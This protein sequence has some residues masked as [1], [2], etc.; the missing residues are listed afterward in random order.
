MKNLLG[1]AI[2]CGV[3]M[4]APVVSTAGS[5]EAEDAVSDSERS[6][7]GMVLLH[8]LSGVERFRCDLSPLPASMAA[9]DVWRMVPDGLRASLRERVEL[10]REKLQ[11]P[12]VMPLPGDFNLTV[13]F[14][15]SVT[16][17]GVLLMV[18]PFLPVTPLLFSTFT[19]LYTNGTLGEWLRFS[20]FSFLSPF[21]GISLYVPNGAFV[22][23][24]YAGLV[25]ATTD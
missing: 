13:N 4:L 17:I 5:V 14:L 20:T 7:G 3:L 10:E 11:A 8:M 23:V 19:L 16:G 2:V 25:V 22:Y 1:V 24:G 12:P 6:A 15:C 9:G 21:V 18:P